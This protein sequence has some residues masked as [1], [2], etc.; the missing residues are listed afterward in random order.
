MFWQSLG[1]S[2]LLRQSCLISMIIIYADLLIEPGV[3]M[4]VMLGVLPG[5]LLGAKILV[6]A[7]T[8]TLRIVFS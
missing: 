7:N 3:T 8:Q 5:A 4:P 6:G 2:A 1:G